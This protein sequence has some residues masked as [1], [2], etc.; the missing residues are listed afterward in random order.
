MA[1]ARILVAETGP[2]PSE[3][4][5]DW[6]AA[7]HERH[8]EISSLMRDLAS[9]G[10]HRPDSLETVAEF[11]RH[12]MPRH[13]AEEEQELFPLLRKR[14]RP[15]DD[16]DQVLGRLCLEHGGDRAR[17]EDL[18]RGVARCL[19]ARKPPAQDPPFAAALA[20]FATQELQHL[21]LENAVVL[22]LARLRLT[23]RDLANLRRRLAER[24]RVQPEPVG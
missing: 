10:D 11:L 6:F 24:R 12:D 17:A 9:A 13:L 19:A 4:P 7:E 23:A 2:R 1:H 21:A 5:L 8:R 14:A 20:T 22:P 15:E 18:E 16:V 3:N